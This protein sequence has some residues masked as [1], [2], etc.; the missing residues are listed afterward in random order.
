M[1]HRIRALVLI[2][3]TVAG[4]SSPGNG[5][6]GATPS[7]T[8][9]PQATPTATSCVDQVLSRLSVSQ[10]IGQLMFL[11]LGANQ[12]G[13]AER[14]SIATYG[15]GSVW[16]TE[17]SNAPATSVASVS[18]QVQSLGPS[19]TRGVGFLIGAN[20]EGGQIDALHGPGFDP[21]PSAVQ[22]GTED[23]ALLQTQAARF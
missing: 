17:L 6:A 21:I 13:P 16:F 12:L 18:A 15:V 3:L 11:G 10:Q 23:P 9:S 1:P 4:C 5:T 8:S 14:S 7:P 19:A 2:V 22:Q 20:Q